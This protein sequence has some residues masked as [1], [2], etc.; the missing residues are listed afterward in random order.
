[1]TRSVDPGRTARSALARRQLVAGLAASIIAPP[2]ARAGVARADARPRIREQLRTPTDQPVD[3]PLDF[4]GLHSDH[5]VSSAVPEPTY[6]YDAIRSHDVDDGRGRSALQWASIEVRPGVYNWRHLDTWIAT[7]PGRTRIFV[8]FGC[9]TFYQKHPREPWRYPHL[10]GGGSPPLDPAAAAAFVAALA[11]RY[12]GE[13]HYLE[14]WNEPNFGPGTDPVHDRWTPELAPKAGFFTGSASDL[15]QMARAVRAVLPAGIK[16]MAAAF[17]GQDG[18]GGSNS[19]LRFASAPDGAGG[20]GRDHVQALSVHCYVY[21]NVPNKLVRELLNYEQRFAEA[22][23][24]R[25]MPRFV[26]ETG[27]EA[28]RFWTAED[29]PLAQKVMGL[30][31]WCLIPAALGWQGVYLYKHSRMG[32]LGDPAHE[33]KLA[34]AITEMRNGLLGQGLIEA[35]VLEDE[36]IRLAFADGSILRA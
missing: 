29:P 5:G 17:E 9:P 13:I 19:L 21:N 25:E 34:A 10:L 16:L 22:G 1:M 18:A 14:I 6:P 31:R 2:V 33:P 28:P 23:F 32:T 24:S 3:I 8:L 20:R 12:P 7:H 11:A 4:L 36:T 15:A 27:A 35:A 30:K 26:T